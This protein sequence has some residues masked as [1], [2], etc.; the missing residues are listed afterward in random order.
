MQIYNVIT[1]ELLEE[2]R[3]FHIP[4]DYR[5]G[6]NNIL[7]ISPPTTQLTTQPE[8]KSNS[9]EEI[10]CK[11]EKCPYSNKSKKNLWNHN[12]DVYLGEPHI[13]DTCGQTLGGKKALKR[14]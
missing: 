1:T 8:V 2:I 9:D 6:Q 14:Q 3:K 11:C 4:I 12:C 5:P 7:M 13:C 10:E